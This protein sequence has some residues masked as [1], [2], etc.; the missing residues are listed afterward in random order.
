MPLFFM[1]STAALFLS[2][3]HRKATEKAPIRNFFLRR[4]F[5]IAPLFYCGAAFYTLVRFEE[6]LGQEAPGYYSLAR[7][8]TTL[9]FTGGLFPAHIM[10]VV[11]GGWSILVEMQFY[12]FVP[13]FFAYT[14]S[15]RAAAISLAGTV[16]LAA[17]LRAAAFSLLSRVYPL[18][19]VGQY[20]TYWLPKQMPFFVSGALLHF[21]LR[22]W[23]QS[24]AR[25]NAVPLMATAIAIIAFT[26][27][28][29]CLPRLN[30]YAYL[31]LW[32]CFGFGVGA[33]QPRLL[34]NR[35]TRYV[36]LI[37]FSGYITHFAILHYIA[38]SL[39]QVLAHSGI[40]LRGN[41]YCILLLVLVIVG[42]GAAS[43]ATYFLV[44]QPG[45]RLGARFIGF[46]EART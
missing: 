10:S 43:T 31:P 39:P 6:R 34:V 3:E 21:A 42:T 12:M 15:V 17:I 30:R 35:I 23:Q 37:S 33:R 24:T 9:S 36:G 41:G 2:L 19:V 7:L 11:P 40:Q 26:P 8:A 25:V 38:R 22:H 27:L 20:V 29:L 13:I 4:L 14:R 32:L 45:R 28:A 44:E 18:E 46:L 16:L 1:A 5:R